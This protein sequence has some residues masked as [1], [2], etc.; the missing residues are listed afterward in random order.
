MVLNIV[1]DYEEINGISNILYYIAA[2]SD[3]VMTIFIAILLIRN[4]RNNKGSIEGMASRFFARTFIVTIPI[5]VLIDVAIGFT[6]PGRFEGYSEI[7]DSIFNLIIMLIMLLGVSGAKLLYGRKN[8][9]YVFRE[10]IKYY[11]FMLILY[12]VVMVSDD[13]DYALLMVFGVAIKLILDFV[14]HFFIKGSKIS[15]EKAISKLEA[16]IEQKE[17]ARIV[18]DEIIRVAGSR[19]VDFFF[20]TKENADFFNKIKNIENKIFSGE[21]VQNL[22]KGYD[23]GIKLDWEGETAGFILIESSEKKLD[24]KEINF[25]IN[26]SEEVSKLAA[27]IGVKAAKDRIVRE[28]ATAEN[29]E[30]EH[31]NSEE[32]MY[33]EKL[34]QLII[35]QTAEEKTKK[36][37]ETI[38]KESKKSRGDTNE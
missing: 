34:A 21:I 30:K 33:I 16:V 31:K 2:S 20:N 13:I 37:A 35:S 19:K 8:N 12:I 10:V 27:N 22:F 11:I 26:F 6:W 4:V 32:L 23:I 28:K 3:V 1:K 18:S 5:V 29:Y 9:S 17:F 15:Y 38:L 14:I 36:L 25:L 7:V 24:I